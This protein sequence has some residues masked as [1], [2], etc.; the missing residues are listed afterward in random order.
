VIDREGGGAGVLAAE[1]IE[2]RPLFTM[3]ELEQFRA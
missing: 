2:L 3:R 1:E